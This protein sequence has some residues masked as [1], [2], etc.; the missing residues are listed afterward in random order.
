[1]VIVRHLTC[2]R[3]DACKQNISDHKRKLQM[4][5]QNPL[6]ESRG[7]ECVNAATKAEESFFT[8]LVPNR[9]EY[10]HIDTCKA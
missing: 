3:I 10:K 7:S 1:M 6:Q 5:S 9:D 2:Q 8:W 4:R